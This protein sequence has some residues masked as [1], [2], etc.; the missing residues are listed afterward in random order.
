MAQLAVSGE[1]PRM[2]RDA[3]MVGLISLFAR[4]AAIE[5]SSSVEIRGVFTF[6]Q[7]AVLV[8]GIIR[9]M[10]VP[11]LSGRELDPKQREASSCSEI[12]EASQATPA[13]S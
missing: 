10:E 6:V 13:L 12:D 9:L 2:E 5:S 7:L 11:K 4:L 3:V 8:V 1:G